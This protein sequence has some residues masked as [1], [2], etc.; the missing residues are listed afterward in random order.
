MM[1]SNYG[2]LCT[3]VYELTKP[4]GTTLNGDIAYYQA[5]LAHTTGLILE[6]GVGSG[7]M[8]LP[9]LEAGYQVHGIDQSPEML[10]RCQHHCSAKGLTT[11]LILGDIETITLDHQYEAI[12]IPTATFCLFATEEIALNV[13]KN[14]YRHLVPGGRL[15]LDL[16][17]PFYPELGEV[18]T[19]VH[20]LT[21]TSG[22]TLE[23][24]TVEIDWLHQHTIT[25]LKYEKWV[26]GSLVATELQELKLRWYGL[27]EFKLLLESIGFATV[28]LSGDY[29]YLTPPSNSN[30]IITF[31]SQK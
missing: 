12:I 16:D 22:I 10:E 25:H 17:L 11:E 23:S 31:E 6:I 1:F 21:E 27:T 7:R 8:L 19:T 9:L 29:D 13:L 26:N 18:T 4:V 20:P 14:C 15:I 5:R 24:K 30:E 2:P 3:E 28:T